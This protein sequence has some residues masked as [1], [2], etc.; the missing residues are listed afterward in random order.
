MLEPVFY[1]LLVAEGLEPPNCSA[2]L[3]GTAKPRC[4]HDHCCGGTVQAGRG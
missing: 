2:H 3:S 4:P 1:L